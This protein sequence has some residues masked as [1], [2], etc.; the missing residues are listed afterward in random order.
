M[1]WP[2][3]WVIS[4]VITLILQEFTG[5]SGLD[6]RVQGINSSVGT[7]STQVSGLDTSVGN[8]NTKVTG[9]EAGL[10]TKANSADVVTK[11]TLAQELYNKLNKG[12]DGTCHPDA[13]SLKSLLNGTL[14]TCAKPK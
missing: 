9:V 6:S 5:V 12:S 10:A 13:D 3:S 14:E 7:L 4:Y 8:L 1:C 2:Q 11:S